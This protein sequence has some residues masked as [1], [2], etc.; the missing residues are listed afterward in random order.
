MDA[1]RRLKKKGVD[2]RTK[3]FFN[4]VE[5]VKT[6][7]GGQQAHPKDGQQEK[8]RQTIDPEGER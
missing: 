4:V 3:G 8:G 1:T 6:V 2:G 5:V 7:D